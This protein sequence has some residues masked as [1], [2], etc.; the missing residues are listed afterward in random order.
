MRRRRKTVRSRASSG[1]WRSYL[2]GLLILGVVI[3]TS[4]AVFFLDTIRRALAEGPD[5]I[6]M[7]QDARGLVPGADVWIAGS[8]SGRVTRVLFADPEGPPDS[9]VVVHAT[10]RRSAARFLRSGAEATISSSSLLAPV[11]LKLTTGD[12]AGPP[13]DFKDTLFVPAARTTEQ[14]LALAASARGAVDTLLTL[15]RALAEELEAGSGSAA[16]FRRDTVLAARMQR[17][18]IGAESVAG[19]LRS[20]SSLPARAAA[21]SLGPTLASVLSTLRQL[22]DEE[23]A[24]EVA[25]AVVTLTRRLERIAVSLDRIDGDL[26]SG[27]G[28]AGRALYDDEIERQQEAA[29]AR[30][31]SLKSELRRRPWRWL[32]VRLF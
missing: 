19:A 31:D 25:E 13:F 28:T 6:V 26:R 15:S 30:L 12:P 27:K 29:R 32:R 18:S 11:V 14:L 23:K 9:R 4:G 10:L 3:T 20:E 1:P 22:G 2:P 21:D 5:V 17:I 16:G 7:A 8:P 24:S